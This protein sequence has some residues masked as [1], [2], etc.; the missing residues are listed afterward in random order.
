MIWCLKIL[1][2]SEMSNI[3]SFVTVFEEII[4]IIGHTPLL[5]LFI[6]HLENNVI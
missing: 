2:P 3:D 6:H 4:I 1:G 5:V